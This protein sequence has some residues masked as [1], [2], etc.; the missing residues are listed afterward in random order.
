VAGHKTHQKFAV[1]VPFGDLVDKTALGRAVVGPGEAHAA[2][3]EHALRVV[4]S[5]R[6]HK[7]AALAGRV[8]E[9]ELV[10]DRRAD[11]RKLAGIPDAHRGAP[12]ALVAID[13]VGRDARVRATATTAH[14]CQ[15]V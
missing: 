13:R 2:V 15:V 14:G 1:A 12:A 4:M 5:R 6:Q 3:P 9:D 7:H 8:L 10:A 11:G